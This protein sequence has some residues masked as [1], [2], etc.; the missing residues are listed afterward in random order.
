MNTAAS[1]P[2]IHPLA[3][4]FCGPRDHV[5]LEEDRQSWTVGR[6]LSLAGDVANAVPAD[7]GERVAVRAR[8][9]AFVVASLVGLWKSHRHP[10][11]LDPALREEAADNG[12]LG[13]GMST[14]VPAWEDSASPE[15]VVAETG[16]GG[17][18]PSL[19][20]SDDT[21]L[22]FFTSGSTGAPKIVR[23]ASMRSSRSR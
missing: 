14:L 23:P 9:A 18:E 16:R 12:H 20:T 3:R 8:S 15:I 4:T 17:F 11:L 1:D 19:P 21:I 10:L 5:F 6:L 13:E 2:A 22:A 7:A